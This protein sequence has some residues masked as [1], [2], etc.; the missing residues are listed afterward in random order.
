M[1]ANGKA[2]P[3]MLFAPKGLLFKTT[4][5]EFKFELIGNY[6]LPLLNYIVKGERLILW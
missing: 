3:L 1:L 6:K 4:V 2:F 5:F